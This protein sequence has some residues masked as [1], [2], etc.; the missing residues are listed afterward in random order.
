MYIVFSADIRPEFVRLRSVAEGW[1]LANEKVGL[2]GTLLTYERESSDLTITARLYPMDQY[3]QEEA[4]S[5]VT[6]SFS[7]LN[8]MRDSSFVLTREEERDTGVGKLYHFRIADESDDSS[9]LH[10]DYF[11]Y[12]ESVQSNFSAHAVVR[13]RPVDLYIAAVEKMAES[14]VCPPRPSSLLLPE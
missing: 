10:L 14:F 2:R 11:W 12:C 3:S 13:D 8:A 1:S 4:R 9:P 5:I 6:I 7:A